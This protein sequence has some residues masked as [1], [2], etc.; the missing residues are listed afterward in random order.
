MGNT[1]QVIFRVDASVDMGTGHV[2][3][4]LTLAERLKRQGAKVRFVCRE[5]DGNLCD[6]VETRGFEVHRLPRPV[7]GSQLD[8]DAP[9]HAAWLGLPW[10][11]D[12]QQF[13]EI[14]S[15]LSTPDWIV[16]DHYALD[17]RWE[18]AFRSAGFN[19]LVIDDLADRDHEC[20]VLLDQNLVAD[21]S[22][23]YRSEG[24]HV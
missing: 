13:Q 20:D 11:E 8:D 16:V 3:R 17:S 22:G 15:T 9:K 18:G 7:S 2:I 6:L 24:A 23:R 5:L 19:I 12:A 14:I 1:V 4:C 10:Q 21:M